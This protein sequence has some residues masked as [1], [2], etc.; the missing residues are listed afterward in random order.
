MEERE[1][2]GREEEVQKQ[3]EEEA[4]REEATHLPEEGVADKRAETDKS[5]TETE[6]GGEAGTSQSSH[7]MI[8]EGAHDQHIPDRLG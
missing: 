8:Q 4:R 2:R 5:G 7:D 6:A 3:R 1:A